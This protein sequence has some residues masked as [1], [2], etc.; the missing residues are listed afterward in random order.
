MRA[1]KL[2]LAIMVVLVAQV[3]GAYDAW[4][5]P[6]S[7]D[8]G[9]TL[10]FPV[11]DPGGSYTNE[12][13]NYSWGDGT[14]TGWQSTPVNSHAYGDNGDYAVH[15]QHMGWH[16]FGY[17]ELHD[18]YYDA[19]V[20]NVDP[21]AN[22]GPDQDVTVGQLVLF[23]GSISDPGWLDT[24]HYEWDFD[25]GTTTGASL[26]PTHTFAGVGIY[27]V[28]L[29]VWD[30]DGGVG[31]DTV[32]IRCSEA[33]GDDSPESSTWVLL[34]FTGVVGTVVRRRWGK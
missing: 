6:I 17:W 33:Q 20:A 19:T 14:S 4:S 27:D 10:L 26:S 13:W 23:G 12:R 22:A 7:G 21:S 15:V 3:F 1:H 25:D 5:S 29:T 18:Y 31:S 8:E 16:P 11:P 2:A 34:G 32:V 30:D 24:L 9:D 28:T